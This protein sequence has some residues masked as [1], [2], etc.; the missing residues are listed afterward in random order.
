MSLT[1]TPH[2]GAR[3]RAAL[4]KKAFKAAF[5]AAVVV[6]V[7]SAGQAQALIVVVNNQLWNVTTIT[8]SAS[9][10]PS[11]VNAPLTPTA[12]ILVMQ[13]WWTGTGANGVLA[14]AF[15]TAVGSGLG[16]P[17][18]NNGSFGPFF[19]YSGGNCLDVRR[20]PS[21]DIAACATA[22]VSYTWAQA[23]LVPPAPG[24]LPL[25][26]AAAAF[27][28]SRKLRKRISATKT[29]GASFTAG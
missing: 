27:G 20:W 22:N 14:Q 4:G 28:F 3:L 8:G 19:A 23:S 18:G 12:E 21:P 17:G 1:E 2:S 26:G 9:F 25:F 24:P 5:G 7:L 16:S 6:G 15:A 10:G 13:P 11:P 29:V